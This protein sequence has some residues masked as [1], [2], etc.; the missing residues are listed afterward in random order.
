MD[1][2]KLIYRF[3]LDDNQAFHKEIQPIS[4]IQMNVLVVQRKLFLLF[5]DQPS[6]SQFIGQALLISRLQETRS[7]GSVDFQGRAENLVRQAIGFFLCGLCDFVVHAFLS[8][9]PGEWGRGGFS[10]HEK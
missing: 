4:A 3:Q 2:K 10:R 5:E 7:D 6:L 8:S 1:R 9:P